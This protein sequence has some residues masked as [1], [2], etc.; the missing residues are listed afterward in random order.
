ML[1]FVLVVDTFR[2]ISKFSNVNEVIDVVNRPNSRKNGVNNASMNSRKKVG[3]ACRSSVVI[4]KFWQSLNV[5]KLYV[6]KFPFSKAA[7]SQDID[8]DRKTI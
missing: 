6:N 2:Q 4:E 7:H 3:L 8:I 1:L 5:N